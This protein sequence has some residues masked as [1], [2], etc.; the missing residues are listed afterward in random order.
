MSA[1][2]QQHGGDHYKQLSP[3]PWD[4]ILAWGMGF[5]EGNVLKYLARW[6]HKGGLDDLRKARHY[7][8][9]L[10]EQ[11]EGQRKPAPVDAASPNL[12]GSDLARERVL[13]AYPEALCRGLQDV[14]VVEKQRSGQVIG[15]GGT[16]GAAWVD[17]FDKLID[18]DSK[19][20]HAA[21][22]VEGAIP[23]PVERAQ[24]AVFERHPNAMC[25]CM[26]NGTH[27]IANG[28]PEWWAPKNR[29]GNGYTAQD[30]WLDAAAKLPKEQCA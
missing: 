4:V 15:Q 20:A 12:I 16:P 9:K 6:R 8:D 10:I 14:Y 25:I 18:D 23:D 2:D 26:P 27:I 30:A 5:V 29:L 19:P 17:A 11:E 3:Q 13:E 24:L 7:L 21:P 28:E 22:I 1:N